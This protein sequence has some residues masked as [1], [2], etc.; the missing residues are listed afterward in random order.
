V[1]IGEY[2]I[3]GAGSVVTRDVPA[4]A[5]AAGNPARVLRYLVT[6][7]TETSP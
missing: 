2:A 6:P 3:V 4:Y 7:D 1:V 5:I